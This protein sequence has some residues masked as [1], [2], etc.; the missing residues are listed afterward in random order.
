[1]SQRLGKISAFTG[2]SLVIAN[3]IGTGVFTSL[4]FQL[5]DLRNTS[6]I[7]VLWITGGIMALSGAFS[8]AEVGTAI[9]RS[10]GEYAF[11]SE[12]FSPLI[13]YLS[14]WISLT[15]GFAAPIALS[16][17]AFTEYLPISISHARLTGV[18]LIFLVTLIHCL[19][20]NVSAGFQN[21]TTSL[22]VLLIASIVVV[23]LVLPA[24]ADNALN[25]EPSFFSELS[26]PV[27]AVC[28][29]YVTYAYSGWNAA[30]YITGEF[31]NVRKALPVALVVGTLV[32]T[33]L[34]TALQYVFMKHAPYD[35][36]AG[37]LDVGTIAAE[38]M[39]GDRFAP[40]FSGAISLLLV[41][42]I[43][44]MVWVGPRVTSSIADD[45]PLWRF[46][47]NNKKGIPVKAL[48]LQA[49]LS[50]VLLLTGTFEQILIYC[51]I[52]LNISALFVIIGVF[53]L[54]LKNQYAFAFKRR[55]GELR[56]KEKKYSQVQAYKSPLFP[57]F[58]FL[59]ILIVCWIIIFSVVNKPLETLV[60]G[61][62]LLVGLVSYF[63]SKRM[64]KKSF[65]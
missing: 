22:K 23:G 60:G 47:Q 40:F 30:A 26:S 46:F 15:V 37:K 51:G 2:I 44:A 31:K 61:L 29:I 53:R 3:M 24:G 19:N 18:A 11:L 59:F 42:G 5:A 36:L 12:I 13:G 58:Q 54:R 57:L 52:L 17:I 7:L 6:V 27:F 33:F 41:S 9:K 65:R 55:Q 34:Y 62:N 8:Y 10:G 4:G 16:A 48:W 20:L 38:Y 43:S 35:A 25:F 49:V 45:H 63:I 50:A 28:L 14:G 32:V 56:L 1:M 39:L 21:I 64:R